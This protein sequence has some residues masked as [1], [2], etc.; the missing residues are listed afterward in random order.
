MGKT[1]DQ[2]ACSL[3]EQTVA[4]TGFEAM[5]DRSIF[6]NLYKGS[7]LRRKSYIPKAHDTHSATRFR[8]DIARTTLPHIARFRRE[9]AVR[10]VLVS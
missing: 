10:F 9:F 8:R 1:F 2:I 7:L 6:S 3:Y 4:I 5:S